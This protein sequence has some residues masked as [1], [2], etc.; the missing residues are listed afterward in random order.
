MYTHGT[1]KI[2]RSRD[3]YLVCYHRHFFSQYDNRWHRWDSELVVV[4]RMVLL[5]VLFLLFLSHHRLCC[6][7]Y[8]EID[9]NWSAILDSKMRMRMTGGRSVLVAAELAHFATVLMRMVILY[10]HL[11]SQAT[12]VRRT[13]LWW[14]SFVFYRSCDHRNCCHP[15]CP[16]YYYDDAGAG[17][18]LCLRSSNTRYTTNSM[19]WWLLYKT[20]IVSFGVASYNNYYSLEYWSVVIVKEEDWLLSQKKTRTKMEE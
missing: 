5:L 6:C 3:W 20:Q 12:L 15:P 19:P 13:L 7:L 1:N 16:C 9:R 18:L 11:S 4:E 10:Y 2:R 8:F 14:H 17:S